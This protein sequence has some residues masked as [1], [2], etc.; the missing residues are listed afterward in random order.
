MR[1]YIMRSLEYLHVLLL[2][3]MFAPLIYVIS[4]QMEIGQIYR[5]YFASYILIVPVIGFMK[6]EKGCKN[7]IQFLLM[8]FCVF[9]GVKIGAEQL[10]LFLLNEKAASIYS[11]CML[12]CTVLI[13][14][15]T[16]ITRIYKIRRKEARDRKDI[17]WREDGFQM[18]KPKSWVIVVFLVI[19]VVGMF[20]TAPPICN[21]TLYHSLFYLLVA[22]AHE[23]MNA[24][25]EYLKM[26]RNTYRIKNIPYIRIYE[27]RRFFLVGYFIL[28]TLTLIPAII[29]VDNRKYIDIQTEEFEV[30]LTAEDIYI[31]ASSEGTSDPKIVP[32]EPFI[33]IPRVVEVLLGASM[34][35]V[36]IMIV[37]GGLLVIVSSIRR[38]IVEF[39]NESEEEEDTIDLLE[40][41]K[42]AEEIL[43]I[44]KKRKKDLVK[45]GRI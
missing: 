45:F 24:I 23:Y 30:E 25:E 20:R 36:A 43:V 11:V 12:I 16:F 2:V 5:M 13:A 6:A 9:L 15:A 1:K 21:L 38:K 7:F 39:A 27:I 17:T 42:D 40:S 34:Y 26:N 44:E 32:V 19:Y 31:Q 35:L 18:D 8:F 29:T 14:L 10:S 4:R 41:F 37:A 3:S 33:V 22:I 28:L